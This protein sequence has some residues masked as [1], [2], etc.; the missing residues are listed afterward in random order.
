VLTTKRKLQCQALQFQLTDNGGS[1][2]PL[3]PYSAESLGMF[4]LEGKT[5]QVLAG[6]RRTY[7]WK[8]PT[9]R[10]EQLP[11]F[12]VFVASARLMLVGSFM[13]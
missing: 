9:S 10:E 7:E 13:M 8:P 2:E 1:H 4:S 3:E 5:E 11:H 6:C 12:C